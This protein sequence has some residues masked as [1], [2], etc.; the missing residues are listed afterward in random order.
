MTVVLDVA[1]LPNDAALTAL[2]Q[3]AERFGVGLQ[4]RKPIADWAK[5]VADGHASENADGVLVLRLHTPIEVKGESEKVSRVTIRRVKVKDMRAA[6]RELRT[7]IILLTAS[8]C[9]PPVFDELES[10]DDA[11]M[12]LAAGARQLGKYLG[13]SPTTSGASSVS[14]AATSG[15][16]RLI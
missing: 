14:S 5:A 9:V 13:S 15:S 4:D 2:Q 3:L 7:D 6:E 16:P 12:L 11:T 10:D 1:S 8:L